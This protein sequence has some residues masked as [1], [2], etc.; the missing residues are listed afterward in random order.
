MN[1]TKNWCHGLDYK[2]YSF[3]IIIIIIT[4]NIKQWTCNKQKLNILPLP[5]LQQMTKTVWSEPTMSGNLL[6]VFRHINQQAAKLTCSNLKTSM[7]NSYGVPILTFC[8]N[9]N[10]LHAG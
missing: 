1:P 7:V 3:I 2:Y 10:I 8:P 5:T 4:E 6:A 9:F